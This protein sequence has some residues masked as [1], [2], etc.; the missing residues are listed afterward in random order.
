MPAP[1][2]ADTSVSGSE[3]L[4]V[5]GVTLEAS[6][7]GAGSMVF[8]LADLPPHGTLYTDF[9]GIGVPVVTG[10]DYPGIFDPGAGVWQV[11]FVFVPDP[12]WAGSTSFH[13][14][15]MDGNGRDTNTATAMLDIVPVADADVVP[16]LR[17]PG[18]HAHQ[19]G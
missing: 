4:L 9:P 5:F 7:S 14:S 15:A 6:D 19:P 12:D 17:F 3:D 8:H 11:F 2:A 1:V 18:A 13:Y 16:A 10:T